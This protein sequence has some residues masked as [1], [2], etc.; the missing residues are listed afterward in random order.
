VKIALT[1]PPVDGEANAALIAFV[2]GSLGLAKKQVRIVRGDTQKTKLLEI[3]G[4]TVD[5]VRRW[6]G[7]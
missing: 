5:A 3:E 4:V 6:I 1:A 7:G 2:A